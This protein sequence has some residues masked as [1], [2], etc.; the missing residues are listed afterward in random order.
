MFVP[1]SPSGTGY[2]LSRLMAAAWA[3]IVSRNVVTTLLQGLRIEPLEGGHGRHRSSG[4]RATAG[5]LEVLFRRPRS[6]ATA[7]NIETYGT[8]QESVLRRS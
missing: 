4:V 3:L 5:S 7:R 8:V 6:L 2:T 1:V